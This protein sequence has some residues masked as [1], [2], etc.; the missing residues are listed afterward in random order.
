MRNNGPVTQQEYLLRDGMAI[1]SKTDRKG[2][3]THVN[4]DFVEASGFEEAELIGQAHNILRHPDMPGEAFRDLWNTVKSG[5]PWSGLVKNR[6]KDG[7]HY[8][9]R[10][11]VTPLPDGG[12]MSVRQRPESGEVAQA[13]ALYRDMR[14]GRSKVQIQRGRV[15]ANP[16]LWH[17]VESLR[18]LSL[19]QRL[20]AMAL[21]G[22][23][24]MLAVGANGV[25]QVREGMLALQS[26][27][28]ERTA[29]INDLA[30][31]QRLLEINAAE[32]LR[33][34]QHDPSTHFAR[35]HDHQAVQH[36]DTIERNRLEIDALWQRYSQRRQSGDEAALV[37]SFTDKRQEYVTHFLTPAVREIRAGSFSTDVLLAFLRNDKGVGAETRNLLGG[38]MNLQAEAAKAEYATAVT[39]YNRVLWTSAGMIVVGGIGFLLFAWLLIRAIVLPV[40]AATR[41]AQAIAQGDL[42]QSLP[43][44]GHDEIGD[45]IVQLTRMRDGLFEM[46]HTI[47]HDAGI[48]KQ[49]A[50][51]LDASAREAANMSEAQSASSTSMAAAVEQ[52]SVSVDQVSEHANAAQDVTLASGKASEQGGRVIMTAVAEMRGITDAVNESARAIHSVEGLSGEIAGI[53]NVI[54]EIADQTNLLALNAAIEAARAGEQGRG[55][56]VVADE[57]RKLAERTGNS[58]Q[59]IAEMIGRIQGGA[60]RAVKEMQTSVSQ[61]EQGMRVASEAGDSM[62]SIQSGSGRVLQSVKDIALALKEQG[63]A[64]QEIAKGVERIAQMCEASHANAGRTATAAARLKHMADRLEADAARFS[65]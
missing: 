37:K 18:R 22:M 53:V 45:L 9:V 29:P 62:V 10:A 17:L 26:V 43:T 3:I 39:R 24:L 32:V 61:V 40:R 5:R 57:V 41:A 49:A 15:I 11:S 51:E 14:D 27:Y 47:R 48:L 4:S 21:I 25:W 6:R 38:L 33:G 13:E 35:L 65:V 60:S 8:W 54:K 58:T 64:A 19:T 42:R 1:I 50:F 34:Y 52:M 44:A 46:T 16:W 30:R 7:A 36:L 20:W 23:L 31:I 59:Q 28:A 55:F 63:T 2:R 12:Y 56:A